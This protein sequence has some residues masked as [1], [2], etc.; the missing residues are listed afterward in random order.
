[1]KGRSCKKPTF[2]KSGHF[3]V[4]HY[5][6]VFDE[7]NLPLRAVEMVRSFQFHPSAFTHSVDRYDRVFG[8]CVC[9]RVFF[10][11]FEEEFLVCLDILV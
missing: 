4:G 5:R 6:Q 7:I 1:M 8:V 2:S 9:V 11:L 3:S 10:F